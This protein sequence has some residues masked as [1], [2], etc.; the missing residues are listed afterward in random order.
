M[1]IAGDIDDSCL[2]GLPRCLTA[3]ALHVRSLSHH[4]TQHF[5]GTLTSLDLTCRG[6]HLLPVRSNCNGTDSTQGM[7]NMFPRRLLTLLLTTDKL[8]DDTLGG[9]PPQLTR[10]EITCHTILSDKSV[11]FLPKSLLVLSLPF[12]NITD[13]GILT[14]PT[15]LTHLYLGKFDSITSKVAHLW[16][17]HGKRNLENF[18]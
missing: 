6:M 10:V 4:G 15:G 17:Y 5:P 18:P 16:P 14:L 2:I 12:T 11:A 3:A 7:M 9:L 13:Q 1:R 8:D